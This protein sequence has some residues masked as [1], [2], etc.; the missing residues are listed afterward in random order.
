MYNRY[1][2]HADSVYRQIPQ[3]EESVKVSVFIYLMELL[4]AWESSV[5]I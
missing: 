2:Q 4:R 3:Q 5:D 1:I